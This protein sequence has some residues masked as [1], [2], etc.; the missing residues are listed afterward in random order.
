VI[1]P[2]AAVVLALALSHPH[3]PD[4]A[5]HAVVE[6][7]QTAIRGSA[8]WFAAPRGTAAAG[9]ALRAFLGPHWRGTVVTV[10]ANG[11]SVTA[12][13]TDWC[14]CSSARVV[15]LDKRSFAK[16]ADPSRGV[17]HVTVSR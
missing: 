15:D 14:L 3:V 10:T 2:L 16:L 17:I 5:P 4:R 6:T 9:P 13:L 1:P 8:T 11:H 7:R 12:R